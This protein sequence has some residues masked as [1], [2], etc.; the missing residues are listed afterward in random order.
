MIFEINVVDRFEGLW[1]HTG[2]TR[3]VCYDRSLFKTY[4]E[5]EDKKVMLGDSHI[6]VVAETG[7]I[8]LQFTSGKTVLQ[9]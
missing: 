3:H 6:T 4:F 9:K 8:E 1:V 5:V 2:A 7:E